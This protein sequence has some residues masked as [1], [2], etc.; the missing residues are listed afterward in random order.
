MSA[1][2]L[3]PDQPE[4][5]EFTTDNLEWAK[6]EIAK[7][8]QGKER[9]AV[10]PLLWQAQR[11]N[12]S[13]VSEPAMRVIADML[14]MPYIRVY[15]VATFYTM[16]NLKPIGRFHVQLC[17]TTP[18]WLRGADDLKKVCNEQIGPIGSTSED[19]LFTWTEVECLGACVN[20]PM[21][22]INDDFYEDLDGKSLLSLLDEIRRGHMPKPG[23]A[24]SRTSSEP[25]SGSTTLT[26][27][28][29]YDPQVAAAPVNFKDR[30]GKV[31][32]QRQD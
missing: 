5:F 16:F 15:E 30:G 17:G 24:R 4:N 7:Y 8:P 32:E 3:S 21:V 6:K 2:R 18:C 22:Q 27:Q 25:Q 28:S 14:G 19:G 20:A 31:S 13:W 29:I 11:Q 9:S 12:S 26:E 23:S 1:R 10:I